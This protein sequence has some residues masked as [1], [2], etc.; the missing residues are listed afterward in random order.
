VREVV[1]CGGAA[2]MRGC[3]VREVVRCGGAACIE[4]TLSAAAL[5]NKSSSVRIMGWR[6]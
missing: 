2:C 4:M 5:S 3:I 1:R 6:D